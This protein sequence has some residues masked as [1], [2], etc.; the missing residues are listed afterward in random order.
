MTSVD[1]DAESYRLVSEA[2]GSFARRRLGPVFDAL[3]QSFLGPATTRE[4]AA[5]EI[6][7]AARTWALL[8]WADSA[9]RRVIDMF[10]EYGVKLPPEAAAVAHALREAR[11]TLVRI[12]VLGPE[13]R[14]EARD[15]LEDRTYALADRHLA[16]ELQAGD[17]LAAWFVPVTSGPTV[18]WRPVEAATWI[19][20]AKLPAFPP[21]LDELASSLP[22]ARERLGATH[23]VHLFWAVYRL[24]N[25]RLP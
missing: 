22:A 21:L 10:V 11:F 20:A 2:A 7:Q 15:L 18:T 12:E 16:A 19:P 14:L 25:G 17:G 8:G 23:P 4:R 3:H 5:P 1:F 9:G 13:D 6:L 24:L